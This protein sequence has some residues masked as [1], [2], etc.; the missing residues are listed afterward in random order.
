M[1]NATGRRDRDDRDTP[2]NTMSTGRSSR[3]EHAT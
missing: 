2:A 3:L 1:I